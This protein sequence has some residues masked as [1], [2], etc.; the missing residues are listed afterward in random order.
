MYPALPEREVLAMLV[1]PV[2]LR[3]LLVP[4]IGQ[5]LAA[6]AVAWLCVAGACTGASL[7]LARRQGWLR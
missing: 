5:G 4:A 3:P 1:E 2:D 7:L 6:L